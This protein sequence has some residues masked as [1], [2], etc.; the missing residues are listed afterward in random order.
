[1]AGHTEEHSYSLYV[2]TTVHAYESRV[3][4]IF[5]LYIQKY[6]LL[7]IHL[8]YIF[9]PFQIA[10]VKIHTKK[11]IIVAHSINFIE[12]NLVLLL[13]NNFNC[14]YD[15]KLESKNMNFD[16]YEHLPV[17]SLGANMTAGKKIF[18]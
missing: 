2:R 1:M 6:I 16:D 3:D 9:I 15:K 17:S 4:N 8:Y 14:R 5:N 12:I 11:N 18:V 13:N 10:G 7:Y